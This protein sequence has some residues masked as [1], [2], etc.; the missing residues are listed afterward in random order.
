VVAPRQQRHG[1]GK[2]LLQRTEQLAAAAQATL[3]FVETSGRPQYAPTRVFYERMGYRLEATLGD[4]Y[5]IGDDK[6]ICSKHLR[7]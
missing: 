7:N 4:F 2:K 3:L 5:A 6:L 1:L